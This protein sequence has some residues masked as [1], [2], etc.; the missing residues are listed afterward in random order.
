[1]EDVRYFNFDYENM[2]YYEVSYPIHDH[3]HYD[4]D[5]N[6]WYE[7]LLLNDD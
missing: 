3:Y 6:A 1:M 2:R 7:D 4:Y 5:E